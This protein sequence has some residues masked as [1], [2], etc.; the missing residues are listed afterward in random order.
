MFAEDAEVKK[1][2]RIKDVSL[3][4]VHGRKAIRPASE[5][6]EEEDGMLHKS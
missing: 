1:I 3:D 5:E 6:E 4:S 2:P